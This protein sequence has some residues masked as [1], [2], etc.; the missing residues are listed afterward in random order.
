MKSQEPVTT[1][2]D[3]EQEEVEGGKER[4]RR[5]SNSERTGWMNN[6]RTRTMAC[7]QVKPMCWRNQTL[8]TGSWKE[9]AWG[10]QNGCG[11]LERPGPRS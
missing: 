10:G 11:F 8:K 3:E 6:A 1:A 5:C 2:Q 9:D 7:R 4:E